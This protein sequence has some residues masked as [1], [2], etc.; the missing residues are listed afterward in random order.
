MPTLGPVTAPELFDP[1]QELLC[2][3][4]VLQKVVIANNS[5]IIELAEAGNR[6]LSG[7][8][9][10]YNTK[11][12]LPPGIYDMTRRVERIRFKRLTNVLPFPIVT[13]ITTP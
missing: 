10:P 12:P 8:A 5:A 7:A 3:G 1:K 9:V 13:I 2:E 11:M 4:S 6:G